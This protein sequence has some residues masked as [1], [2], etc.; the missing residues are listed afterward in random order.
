MTS[1]ELNLDHAKLLHRVKP[2][3]WGLNSM[4]HTAPVVGLA[5]DEKPANLLYMQKPMAVYVGNA[6]GNAENAEYHV[7][8]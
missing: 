5:I 4:A 8:P 2:N 1:T 7:V 3:R 6:T